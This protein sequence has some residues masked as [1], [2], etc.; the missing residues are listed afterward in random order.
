MSADLSADSGCISKMMPRVK[1]VGCFSF[2]RGAGELQFQ[3]QDSLLKQITT[4]FMLHP[5]FV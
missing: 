3:T 2:V 5:G 4:D 1:G